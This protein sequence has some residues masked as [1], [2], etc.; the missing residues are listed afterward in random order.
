M[1]LN[2]LI[3]LWTQSGNIA[4]VKR[5]NI[6]NTNFPAQTSLVNY[7]GNRQLMSERDKKFGT[8]VHE[9]LAVLGGDPVSLL[10]CHTREYK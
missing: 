1:Y 6:F 8:I 2:H 7:H 9:K 5:E 3:A 10:V 4:L